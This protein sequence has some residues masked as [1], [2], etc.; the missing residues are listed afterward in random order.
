[1][2]T[3]SFVDVGVF[4]AIY[5][6]TRFQIGGGGSSASRLW[7]NKNKPGWAP[8]GWMFPVVWETIYIAYATSFFIFTRGAIESSWQLWL[9]FVA[10]FLHM[11]GNK[12]WS[13]AFWDMKK[14]KVALFILLLIMFPTAITI[15]ISMMV[16]PSYDLYVL[17]GCLI[18]GGIVWLCV[19]AML[20]IYWVYND[21]P[22][23]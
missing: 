2:A 14:P 1:M 6:F 13:V 19:A 8:P 9:G 3:L 4:L 20:N 18:I 15:V 22:T 23:K 16:D 12:Y 17:S 21:F 5:A 10:Y 7:Y 11:M